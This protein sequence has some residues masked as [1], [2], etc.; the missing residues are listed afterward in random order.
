MSVF[1]WYREYE[2]QL[3]DAPECSGDTL[4]MLDLFNEALACSDNQQS[5]SYYEQAGQLARQIGNELMDLWVFVWLLQAYGRIGEVKQSFDMAV[6]AAIRSRDRKYDG[7]PIGI[8][9]NNILATRL[10]EMDPH[11]RRAEIA[12][13]CEYLDSNCPAESDHACIFHGTMFSRSLRVGDL[14]SAAHYLAKRYPAARAQMDQC[15]QWFYMAWQLIAEAEIAFRKKDWESMLAHITEGLAEPDDNRPQEASLI[16]GQA[17]AL[18]RLG[19]LRSAAGKYRR[20]IQF[21]TY[22]RE[23]HWY[24]FVVEYCLAIEDVSLAI[25]T[26]LDQQR[27]IEGKGRCWEQACGAQHL[28]EL[29]RGQGEHAQATVW[30]E[31]LRTI[32]ENFK[33]PWASRFTEFWANEAASDRD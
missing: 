2:S 5:I 27:Q 30:I 31:K 10:A 15:G 8:M 7:T 24:N 25:E 20:A 9:A 21:D 23:D 3:L 16:A 32:C 6:E 19:D 17:C 11:G 13:A 26:R 33:Q 22:D 18:A 12:A 29:Y 1:D 4:R 14:E 28:I